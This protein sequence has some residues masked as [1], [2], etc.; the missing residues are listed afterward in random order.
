M[1]TKFVG[2]FIIDN[3]SFDPKCK[4]LRDLQ[5]KW[6]KNLEKKKRLK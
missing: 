4:N 1:Q 2:A 6:N 5:A 3:T